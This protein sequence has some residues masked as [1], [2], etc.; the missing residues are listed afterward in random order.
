MKNF[1]TVRQKFSTEKLDTHP[2]F[3]SKVFQYLKLIKHLR[4][5]PRDFFGTVRFKK[6]RRNILMLPPHISS[7]NFLATGKFL[8]HSTEGFPS[9]TF[10]HCE[11]KNFRRKILITPLF[12][13][14]LF[15]YRKI[16]ET[17]H[18]RV[19]LTKFSAL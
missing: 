14:K 9:E 10:W 11:T 3:L 4:I 13:R 8:K 7:I 6:Y 18:R 15:R 12:I 17:Q 19:H 16:S 2:P 1:G 5:P